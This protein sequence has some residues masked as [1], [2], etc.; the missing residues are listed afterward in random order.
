MLISVSQTTGL[1]VSSLL[2]TA[3]FRAASALLLIYTEP[4]YLI[5]YKEGCFSEADLLKAGIVPSLLL[6]VAATPGICYLSNLVG[7]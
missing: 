2:L 3:S 4:I 7:F 6:S 1:S 5:A